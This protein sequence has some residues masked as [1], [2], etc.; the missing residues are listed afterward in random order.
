ML[1]QYWLSTVDTF[2][3]LLS[4]LIL[5]LNYLR[6]KSVF[7]FLKHPWFFR[8]ISSYFKFHDFSHLMTKPTKWH[9]RPAKT[10]ISLVIRLVWSESS[11]SAWRK[12]GSLTTLWAQAKTNQTGQMPR[13]IWGFT[14]STCHFVGFVVRWLIFPCM[15]KKISFFYIFHVGTLT[16]CPDLSDWKD[17]MIIAIKRLMACW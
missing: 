16:V 2:K 15:E 14:G 13:L 10:R 1:N 12:L 8:Y 3:I 6:S 5:F 4:T 9:V 7:F 11:L 17:I